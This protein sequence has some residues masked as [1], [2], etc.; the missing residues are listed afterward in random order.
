VKI[1]AG[2]IALLHRTGDHRP[3]SKPHLNG[4]VNIFG[5]GHFT[6]PEDYGL[7]HQR[8][9]EAVGVES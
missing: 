8:G 7:P 2:E 1:E 3:Q 9:L 5:A 6:R 4:S